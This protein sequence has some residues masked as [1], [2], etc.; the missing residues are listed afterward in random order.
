M[1]RE[2]RPDRT[3]EG[4]RK[5]LKSK[6]ESEFHVMKRMM[7]ANKKAYP[8]PASSAIPLDPLGSADVPPNA[9]PTQ[10]KP[11]PVKNPD[12]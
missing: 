9:K 4:A 11:D 6:Q 1:P 2:W 10:P 8:K 5:L 12:K 7:D 3:S